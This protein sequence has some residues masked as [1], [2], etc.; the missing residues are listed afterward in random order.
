[1][2]HSAWNMAGENFWGRVATFYINFEKKFSCPWE[3]EEQNKVLE[4][5]TIIIK[6]YIIV[7]T[8]YN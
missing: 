8:Y 7:N 4:A 1:V 5:S 3:F 6:Y 2:Y